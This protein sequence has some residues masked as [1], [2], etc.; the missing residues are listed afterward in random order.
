MM[1]GVSHVNMWLAFSLKTVPETSTYYHIYMT[2]AH[3]MCFDMLAVRRVTQ[4][5]KTHLN[6]ILNSGVPLKAI[7]HLAPSTD[8]PF[9]TAL[10]GARYY[11][12]GQRVPALGEMQGIKRFSIPPH[13]FSTGE[14]QPD[15]SWRDDS[16]V[17]QER[18]EDRDEQNGEAE[19]EYEESEGQYN[20]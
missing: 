8:L 20:D 12:V 4:V 19:S 18:D 9:E 17:M 10:H 15:W 7:R 6:D 3:K 5:V 13:D 11:N 1:E 14:L 16:G 2:S